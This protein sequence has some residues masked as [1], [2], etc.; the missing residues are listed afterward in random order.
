MSTESSRPRPTVVASELEG[1]QPGGRCPRA[2]CGG[3]LILRAVVTHSG[4]CDELVCSSCSRTRLLAIR[5]PY[6]PT[7][8]V[9]DPRLECLLA[10]DLPGRAGQGIGDNED[11]AVPLDVLD[12]AGLRTGWSCECLPDSP[13]DSL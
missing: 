13:P 2:H 9:R 5:E 7:P 12:D 4:G 1:H 11:S 10:P 3:L 6:V 8:S